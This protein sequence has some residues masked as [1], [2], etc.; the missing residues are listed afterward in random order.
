M[1]RKLN[2]H[3][4]L[5]N[6][7]NLKLYDLLDLLTEIESVML[8][9][10]YA[11]LFSYYNSSSGVIPIV[12]KLPHFLQEKWTALASSY[13]KTHQVSFRT[14]SLFVRFIRELDIL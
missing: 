14:F 6:K 8:N 5:T 13:K 9:L 12:S 10:R 1:K 3:H 2:S 7:D 11:T 4:T